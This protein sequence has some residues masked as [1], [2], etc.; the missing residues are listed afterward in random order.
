MARDDRWNGRAG[1]R[2]AATDH[3]D[4]DEGLCDMPLNVQRLISLRQVA[5]RGSIAK[6]AQDLHLT[7][8]AVSQHLTKL[9]HETGSVLLEPDGRGIRVTEAGHRLVAHTEV[10]LADME[11]AET[12][13]ASIASM[14][15]GDVVVGTFPTGV[16]TFLVAAVLDVS[17]RYPAVRVRMVEGDPAQSLMGLR[18]RE[19]DMVLG[20]EYPHVPLDAELGVQRRELFQDPLVLLAP[21]G[22]FRRGE[23]VDLAQLSGRSWAMAPGRLAFGQG[24]RRI[25]EAAGFSADIRFQTYDVSVMEALV[26]AGLAIA[27]VPRLALLAHPVAA[28]VEEHA[29][30]GPAL[31]RR[32]FVAVRSGPPP[33]PA[34]T[35]AID[36]V[37]EAASGIDLLA[38]P[39]T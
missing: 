25:C 2:H 11:A 4:R 17:R 27:I 35:A 39:G 14:P 20:Y 36:A 26:A 23:H 32:V 8:A 3:G 31:A 13:L 5:V 38:R 9:E 37:V 19:L 1:R 24:V 28:G 33:R 6:A 22:W 7:A 34:V 10:I 29:I 30:A 21:A 12:D 18:L 16:A 15:A